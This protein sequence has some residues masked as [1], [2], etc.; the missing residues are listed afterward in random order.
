MYRTSEG[1]TAIG[2]SVKGAPR[3]DSGC[4]AGERHPN[5]Q[6]VPRSG[7]PTQQPWSSSRPW[8]V[9]APY[10]IRC[11]LTGRRSS[12]VSSG[13]SPPGG[14]RRRRGSRTSRLW[15]QPHEL[16]LLSDSLH[17]HPRF[18]VPGPRRS[19]LLNAPMNTKRCPTGRVR[20]PSSRRVGRSDRVL[21]EHYLTR[22][23]H[24]LS[25]AAG[26]AAALSWAVKDR[27]S[28]TLMPSARAR[29]ARHG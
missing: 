9:K 23:P 20:L 25:E 24:P 27:C 13:R 28:W 7:P 8:C 5:H 4:L 6:C 10:L 29:F 2:W 19:R 3:D 16:G 22:A 26:M 17:D 12:R 11:V 14:G 15:T 21:A 18:Q 1:L